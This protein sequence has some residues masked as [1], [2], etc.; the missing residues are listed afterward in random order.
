MT[1]KLDVFA[2]P[3]V[4]DGYVA[5]EQ[6]LLAPFF[7]NLTDAVYVPLIM[8]PE[9]IGALCSRASRAAGDLR[10]VFLD[11]YVVPFLDSEQG[12]Y[13]SALSALIDFLQEHSF[14]EVFSNPRA[15][16]FY[17]KWL[18]QYGDDSIAQMAGAHVIFGALSQVAIKHLE[19]QRI[20]L[21]PI[22]KSTRYV[23][24][25]SKVGGHFRYYVDPT[26][27]DLGMEAEYR[28]AMDGLFETYVV[29]KPKLTAHLAKKFPE[30]KPSV[31]EKK[32]FDTLRGLLPASTLSQ[33]AFFG[34]GQA[35]EYMIARSARH[36]LGEI[37]WAAQAALDELSRMVPSFLRRLKDPDSRAVA[38]EYQQ[39]LAGRS[40]RVA[41][42][43]K[44]YLAG[45]QP[46]RADRAARP[47]VELV[48]FDP[49]GEM[50]IIAAM[51]YSAA[52]N[53]ASWADTMTAVQDMSESERTKVVEQY[54]A[55]RGERWQKVGR[56]F[57]QA[58]LRYEIIM[59]IGAWRDLH[60]HRML[61]QQRQQFSVQHGYDV[62]PEIVEAGLEKTFRAAIERA[63]GAYD[64]L[65]EHD[66]ELAQYAVTL[67]HRVRFVQWTNVRECFWE[68]ELRTIPEG[69]PDYRYIEQEKFRLF[70]QAYPLLARHMRVNM[71]DYD[72]A[73]RGQDEKIQEK[74]KS[75]S[76]MSA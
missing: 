22:E 44:H 7:T 50:T 9:V 71:G 6:K 52:G 39:Y 51:L 47:R 24:Y 68:M 12:G 19:D 60:R 18:A 59:N 58:Y 11:E 34:N 2:P 21:A 4:P 64:T 31:V 61:T 65:A 53:R 54:L 45:A 43:A 42:A 29:L 72:F 28:A 40:Q 76:K 13:G 32:A 41:A 20:G 57:E 55:G 46:E 25:S 73:R 63:E 3:F 10:K 69:H 5:R 33:V 23:D 8:S 48:D 26:L 56:A 37:R 27:A 49:D 36:Q 17:A 38:E 1:H 74:L 62:P 15:R 66:L 16:S 35:L 70:E 75:L 14:E 67:A 30:E